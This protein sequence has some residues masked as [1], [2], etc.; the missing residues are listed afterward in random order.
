M[1]VDV[2]RLATELVA[3]NSEP[4]TTEPKPRVRLTDPVTY[5]CGWCGDY[6]IAENLRLNLLTGNNWPIHP[7]CVMAWYDGG[8]QTAVAPK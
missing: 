7:R 4:P 3:A 6:D 2:N 5:Q 1:N 8:D